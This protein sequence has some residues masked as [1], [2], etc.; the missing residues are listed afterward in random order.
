M[1]MC[2][3][4]VVQYINFTGT[5]IMIAL[6]GYVNLNNNYGDCS[7]RVYSCAMEITCAQLCI[8]TDSHHIIIYNMFTLSRV[9][10]IYSR[11]LSYKLF[12]SRPK[13]SEPQSERGHEQAA[14]NPTDSIGKD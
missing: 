4:Q 12:C 10:K 1:F 8:S 9:H 6:L 5:I 7:I 11:A 2:K 3:L 13:L 14:E